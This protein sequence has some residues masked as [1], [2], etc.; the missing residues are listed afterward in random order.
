M[1]SNGFVLTNKQLNED[2]ED[3][4]FKKVMS[5]HCEE[6]SK[7]ILE[8]IA[9]NRTENI[10]GH[11]EVNKIFNQLD[12]KDNMR[13]LADIAKKGFLFA[14]SFVF[15]VIVSLSSVV[16][17]SAEVRETV[18]DILYHLVFE[19]N[20]RYT[21]ISAGET[22]GFIDPELYDWEGAYAPTYM[23]E[24]FE[25][26]SR[27]DF[28]DYHSIEYSNGKQ[29]IYIAQFYEGSYNIDTEEAEIVKHTT[30]NG[31]EAFVVTK[32]NHSIV[33][34]SA[35]QIMMFVRGNIDS[36]ELINIAEN[37]KTVK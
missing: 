23:P 29:Q 19:E 1:K 36:S 22:T 6:E 33:C 24:G 10:S 11:K 31:S 18:T 5:I 32:R 20:E 25:F 14:A 2:Y 9:R 4:I 30:I 26:L 16:V 35:D 15:V 17:A 28:K 37:M 21:K 8:E 3:L 12:R 27:D 34:W 13:I 7:E